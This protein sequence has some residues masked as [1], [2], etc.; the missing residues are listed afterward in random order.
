MDLLVEPLVFFGH[1]KSSWGCYTARTALYT[2]DVLL[3]IYFSMK[4]NK[5]NKLDASKM[6]NS[7]H[8]ST[9]WDN[10]QFTE[11]PVFAWRRVW[12]PQNLRRRLSSWYLMPFFL[13]PGRV[14]PEI[15][16]FPKVYTYWIPSTHNIQMSSSVILLSYFEVSSGNS[17][18]HF[19]PPPPSHW[20]I[21]TSVEAEAVTEPTL[22]LFPFY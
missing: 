13:I 5:I 1:L 8:N 16:G 19:Y 22:S 14:F 17:L 20:H 10:L 6:W 4:L 7:Q 21:S 2:W 3:H 9:H 11:A 18:V 12:V 15:R